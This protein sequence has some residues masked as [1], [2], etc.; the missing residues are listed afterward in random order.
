MAWHMCTH[1]EGGKSHQR[2]CFPP[3]HSI[4]IHLHLPA[5]LSACLSACNCAGHRWR[6]ME[7]G[8]SLNEE[9][10]VSVSVVI[11]RH[12]CGAPPLSSF[13]AVVRRARCS[14]PSWYPRATV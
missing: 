3:C 13:C 5:G 7:E 11:L 8:A 4:Y 2:P 1:D 10:A 9:V 12:C 14:E 6:A